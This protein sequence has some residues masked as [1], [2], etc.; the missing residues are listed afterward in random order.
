M[1]VRVAQAGCREAPGQIDHPGRRTYERLNV[2]GRPTARTRP[3]Q[4]AMASATGSEIPRK[5]AAV[6]QDNIGIGKER[7][8]PLAQQDQLQRRPGEEGRDCIP[9]CRPAR[10]RMTLRWENLP[11]KHSRC[12]ASLMRQRPNKARMKRECND[13]IKILGPLARVRPHRRSRGRVGSA[14]IRAGDAGYGE[15]ARQDPVRRFARRP[16]LLLRGRQGRPPRLRRR[17]LPR[18]L[19]GDLR[20]SRQGRVCPAEHE[21]PLPGG[22]IRRGRHPVA[23]EHLEL[24]ARQL[25]RPRFRARRLLRRPGPHGAG[26]AQREERQRTHR[27][28]DL[29]AARHDDAAEPR[30]LLPAEEHQV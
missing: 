23:P 9:F 25:A 8:G 30:G 19:G 4:I 12:G 14:C 1:H 15:E 24:L 13:T 29:P 26:E 10:S 16:R 2:G 21:C 18:R 28:R 20:R 3:A 5:D 27:G 22:S 7:H 6:C 11:L 17:Y